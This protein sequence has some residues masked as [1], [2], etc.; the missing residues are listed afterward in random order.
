M[1]LEEH[2]AAAMETAF[3]AGDTFGK[4]TCKASPEEQ[5]AT[6]LACAKAA[7]EAGREYRR[8]QE[9]RAAA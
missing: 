8:L 9:G 2:L 5:R 7:I 1:T 4:K 6:W 3:W